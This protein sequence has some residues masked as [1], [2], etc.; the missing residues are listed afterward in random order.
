MAPAESSLEF[1][2]GTLNCTF[3][4]DR[5]RDSEEKTVQVDNNNFV[6]MGCYLRDT[7]SI[8]GIVVYVGEDTLI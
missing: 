5:S 4:K 1:W 7:K 3:Y 6:R 8:T 2:E